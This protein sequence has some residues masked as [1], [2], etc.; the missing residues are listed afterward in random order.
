MCYQLSH[1]C[2][3]TPQAGWHHALCKT[4]YSFNTQG[5]NWENVGNERDCWKQLKI[6]K[7][8]DAH[9]A[10][11]CLSFLS[12]PFRQVRNY[13]ILV[14]LMCRRPKVGWKLQCAKQCVKFEFQEEL[15][16]SYSYNSSNLYNMK[17]MLTFWP[18][19][20]CFTTTWQKELIFF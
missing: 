13:I 9:W 14:G 19:L 4:R 7:D 10:F 20:M 1:E 18:I 6:N 5:C 17:V 2:G 3:K 15:W 12:A 8:I 11:K 16:S